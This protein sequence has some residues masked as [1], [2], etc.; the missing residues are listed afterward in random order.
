MASPV[1]HIAAPLNTLAIRRD[2]PVLQQDIGACPLVYFDNAASSQRPTAVLKAMDDFYQHDYANIHRGVHTLSQRATDAFEAARARVARFL[3]AQ[4][5]EEIIITKNATEAFNLLA[6][7]L[8]GLLQQGDEVLVSELEHHANLVPWQMAAQRYGLT[9][10]KIP[11]TETGTIDPDD[12]R[13]RLTSR[14][15]IVAVAHVSNVMGTVV[16]IREISQLA[17]AAGAWMV[18]DGAQAAPRMAVNVAQLGADFYVVTGHKLYGPSGIGALYGR[19]DLLQKMP[20][21]QGGGNMISEV[22]FDH[23]TWREPPFRFEAGTPPIAEAIGFAAALD[24][25]SALSLDAVAAHEDM[26]LQKAEA[27][28]RTMSSVRV[29][30]APPHRAGILSL[31]MDDIHAHDLGTILDQHGIAVRAGHHCAQPLM[32][33]MGVPATLRV[34]F[35]LYNTPDEIDVLENALHD[36][37]KIFGVA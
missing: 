29:L 1:R 5:A 24:Y 3:G 15:K 17:H 9:L 19:H 21:W 26:L 18:V 28:L 10:Q 32:Q 2:F 13:R 22:F 31:V 35:G 6:N 4:R 23:S 27:M 37:K 25:L 8:G 33:R 30:G 34:S 7:S 14:T 16:P 12:V 36:A 11:I 20:P